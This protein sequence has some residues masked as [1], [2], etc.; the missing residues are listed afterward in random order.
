[1]SDT[2]N[3]APSVAAATLRDVVTAIYALRDSVDKLVAE[4][5]AAAP[6]APRPPQAAVAPHRRP[7]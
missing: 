2:T 7:T 3:L 6:L 4:H 5:R 1:M